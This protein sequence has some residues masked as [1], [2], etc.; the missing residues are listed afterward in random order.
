MTNTKSHLTSRICEELTIVYNHTPQR[1]QVGK[2]R[3]NPHNVFV[4]PLS[5]GVFVLRSEFLIHRNS[6]WHFARFAEKQRV[7]SIMKCI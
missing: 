5:I 7:S 4:G 6:S 1:L 3:I 2:G